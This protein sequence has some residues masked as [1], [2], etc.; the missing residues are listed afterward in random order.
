MKPEPKRKFLGIP[1]IIWQLQLLYDA[2]VLILFVVLLLILNSISLSSTSFNI[3]TAIYII[4]VII[5]NILWRL[6]IKKKC[7][8][9]F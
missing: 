6:A 7:P 5:V 8:E 2:I 3:T 4:V 1:L 9:W